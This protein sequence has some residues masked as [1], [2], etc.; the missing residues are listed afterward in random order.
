MSSR[1]L[2]LAA[3]VKNYRLPFF[4]ALYHSLRK[5][6]IELRVLYGN[7]NSAHAA[8][9]DNVY[10]PSAYSCHDGSYWI[11]DRLMVHSAWHE[12]SSAAASKFY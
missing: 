12:I 4:E 8:R 10:L 11:A 6:G 5:D 3:H 1:V 9:R 7:P 2:F